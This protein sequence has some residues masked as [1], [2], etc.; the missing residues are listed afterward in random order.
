MKI[1]MFS[2]L[3]PCEVKTLQLDFIMSAWLDEHPDIEIVAMS[4]SS[5]QYGEDI[6]ITILYRE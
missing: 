4:Q 6:K 1:K 3:Y 2:G 5:D